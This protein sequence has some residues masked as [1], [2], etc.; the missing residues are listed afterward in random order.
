M[1]NKMDGT[2]D[3]T[4]RNRPIDENKVVMILKPS[5]VKHAASN[6]RLPA[7][8]VGVHCVRQDF[9]KPTPVSNSMDAKGR[10]DAEVVAHRKAS[11]DVKFCVLDESGNERRMTKAE[12]KAKKFQIAQQKKKAKKKANAKKKRKL[13]LLLFLIV[14]ETFFQSCS[15][16]FKYF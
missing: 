12:K 8:F 4:S 1:L 6:L 9:K 5:L 7:S 3:E 13:E 2:N 15:T 11:N 14:K 16:I 10:T